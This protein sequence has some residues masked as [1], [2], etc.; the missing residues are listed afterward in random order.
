MKI[1]FCTSL[2]EIIKLIGWSDADGFDFTLFDLFFLLLFHCG[3]RVETK[4]SIFYAYQFGER[5]VRVATC[6]AINC[7]GI[8]A[9]FT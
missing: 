8:V 7:F 4:K 1:G 9:I 2:I 6:I 5:L 3:F